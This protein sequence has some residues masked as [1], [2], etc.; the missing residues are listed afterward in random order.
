MECWTCPSK[1]AFWSIRSLEPV[2]R[3]LSGFNCQLVGTSAPDSAPQRRA[4]SANV[5]TVRQPHR[6]DCLS[7][8]PTSGL[9]RVRAAQAAGRNAGHVQSGFIGP[10]LADQVARTGSA[11]DIR[12]DCP[13]FNCRCLKPSRVSNV[14]LPVRPH[15]PQATDLAE[16]E[17]RSGRSGQ[18]QGQGHRLILARCYGLAAL[19]GAG[20][21]SI[22]T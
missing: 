13:D 14:D 16:L 21:T 9:R 2:R 22:E 3:T 5:T 15:G 10:W 18:G 20:L 4:I 8:C 19:P 11:P 6:M 7:S 12:L 1:S 17:G